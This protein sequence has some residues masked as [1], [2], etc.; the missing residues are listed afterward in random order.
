[1]VPNRLKRLVIAAQAVE[2]ISGDAD[3]P[4]RASQWIAVSAFIHLQD[5]VLVR[6]AKAAVDGAA[7]AAIAVVGIQ[8]DQQP[9]P[10]QAMSEILGLGAVVSGRFGAGVNQVTRID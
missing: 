9:P 5:D 8:V 2:P 6:I 3:P 1:M 4:E 7:H 10:S